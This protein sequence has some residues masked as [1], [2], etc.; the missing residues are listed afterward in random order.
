MRI[1]RH[2][3]KIAV[4]AAIIAG[5]TLGA[6]SDAQADGMDRGAR[7]AYVRPYMDRFLRWW[8]RRLWLG[9]NNR[10]RDLDGITPTVTFALV[11]PTARLSVCRL[12][13]IRSFREL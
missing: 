11:T 6:A 4:G 12:A 1:V 9:D 7:A 5:A 2:L 13:T 3:N 8:Q 10:V